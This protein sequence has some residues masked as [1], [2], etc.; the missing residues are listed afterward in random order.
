MDIII[1]Y[2]KDPIK[3]KQL[4]DGVNFWQFMNAFIKIN[5]FDHINPTDCELLSHNG[6]I[7]PNFYLCKEWVQLPSIEKGNPLHGKTGKLFLFGPQKSNKK[8]RQR[9][10]KSFNYLLANYIIELSTWFATTKNIFP[11]DLL[12]IEFIT[13]NRQEGGREK[14]QGILFWCSEN[15]D[16]HKFQSILKDVLK[17][18]EDKFRIKVLNWG[19]ISKYPD[20][21]KVE[22]L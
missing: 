2:S 9:N 11:E 14:H 20:N 3:I 16:G 22:Y 7:T 17:Y 12:A 8:N 6:K 4:Q 5:N 21:T 15:I 13:N 1:G 18:P 10:I 19:N